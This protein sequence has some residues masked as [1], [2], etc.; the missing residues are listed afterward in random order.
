M[1]WCCSM[2]VPAK[3]SQDHFWFSFENS[4]VNYENWPICLKHAILLQIRLNMPSRFP[5]YFIKTHTNI[6]KH[7]IRNYHYLK[8]WFN[9]RFQDIC[10]KIN[11]S[12]KIFCRNN[13]N[14]CRIQ[15]SFLIPLS[16]LNDSVRIPSSNTKS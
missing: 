3:D 7:L 10:H 4:I 8:L 13:E 11:L 9:S 2:K 6:N 12:I 1:F 14:M 16:S 15:S 5:I